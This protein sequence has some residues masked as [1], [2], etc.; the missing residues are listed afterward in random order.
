MTGKEYLQKTFQRH[1]NWKET[2]LPCFKAIDSKDYLNSF[3]SDR[4]HMIDAEGN[5]LSAP[6]KWASIGKDGGLPL[7]SLLDF[8]DSSDQKIYN[9]DELMAI[10]AEFDIEIK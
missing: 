10:V 8:T 7:P 5:W 6:P 4:S 3:T 9:L 2:D 1:E